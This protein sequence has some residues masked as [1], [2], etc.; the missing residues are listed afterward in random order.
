MRA[1]AVTVTITPDIVTG[2]ITGPTATA[3][4]QANG[5]SASPLF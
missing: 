3:R 1:L 4:V 2:M 5:G